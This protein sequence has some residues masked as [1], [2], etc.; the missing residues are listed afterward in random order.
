MSGKRIIILCG[1]IVG[2]GM[3]FSAPL[4]AQQPASVA[5]LDE[6]HDES[7]YY[8]QPTYRPDTRE[9]IH[10]KAQTRA[11]QRQARLAS[12]S[13]YGMSNA[14]PTAAPTPFMS[15]YSPVWQM[16]GGR[17]F[18]WHSDPWPTYVFYVR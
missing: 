10:Q 7:L 16:P 13:W 2:T 9:I 14:R 17:P 11:L 15:L 4:M 8:Q 12:M 5:R 18:A 1:L 6:N 3:G